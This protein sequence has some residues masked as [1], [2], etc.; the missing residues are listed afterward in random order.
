MGASSGLPIADFVVLLPWPVSTGALHAE[1]H[2][3]QLCY[4]AGAVGLDHV[5]SPVLQL[6]EPP[7]LR[8][9][10]SGARVGLQRYRLLLL[11][12]LPMESH[13]EIVKLC[14]RGP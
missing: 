3:C 14:P 9:V 2:V 5:H 12:P 1:V 6:R 13:Q 7:D 10:A 4:L 11:L 8:V